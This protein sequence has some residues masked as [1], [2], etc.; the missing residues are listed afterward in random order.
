MKWEQCYYTK[1]TLIKETKITVS[2]SKLSLYVQPE[3]SV[4][5]E[6]LQTEHLTEYILSNH[7]LKVLG[8]ISPDST[9]AASLRTKAGKL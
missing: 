7:Y 2:K 3:H 8:A 5:N 1:R 9:W 4:I 6:T